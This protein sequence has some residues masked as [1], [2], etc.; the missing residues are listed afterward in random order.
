MSTLP[1]DWTYSVEELR[2]MGKLILL[3]SNHDFGDEDPGTVHEPD[4]GLTTDVIEGALARGREESDL[5]RGRIPFRRR[6]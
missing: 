5:A 2:R 4:Y 1:P 3:V 6:R